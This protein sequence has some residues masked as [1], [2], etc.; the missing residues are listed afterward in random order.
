M[1]ELAA[2]YIAAIWL[3]TNHLGKEGTGL[4]MNYS[5]SVSKVFQISKFFDSNALTR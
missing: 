5:L 3:C 4:R 1:A 2:F